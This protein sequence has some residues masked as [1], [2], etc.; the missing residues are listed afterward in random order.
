MI[1]VISYF[2]RSKQIYLDCKQRVNVQSNPKK[3]LS[4]HFRGLQE[5]QHIRILIMM[6]Q[7]INTKTSFLPPFAYSHIETVPS[8]LADA[9]Y[10]PFGDQATLR[11]VRWW[12]SSKIAAQ[13][14]TF[15]WISKTVCDFEYLFETRCE[16]FCLLHKMREL[17]RQGAMKLAKLD[18]DDLFEN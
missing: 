14:Q 13:D 5:Q 2:P 9:K 17:C 11:T 18:Q 6:N 7:K 15:P 4:L 16:Y 10:L 1:I 3:L 8:K 12:P